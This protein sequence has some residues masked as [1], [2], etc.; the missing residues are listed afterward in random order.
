MAT[1]KSRLPVKFGQFTKLTEKRVEELKYFAGGLIIA[2]KR[3]D[4]KAWDEQIQKLNKT[5]SRHES[6]FV[7]ALCVA[8]AGG[9]RDE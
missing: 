6:G 7:S 1:R 9:G 5:L 3:D 8:L 2:Y 4:K